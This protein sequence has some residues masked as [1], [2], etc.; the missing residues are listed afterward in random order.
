MS[1]KIIEKLKQDFIDALH[2]LRDVKNREEL[3]AQR[4]L[5]KRKQA[6]FLRQSGTFSDARI[7]YAKGVADKRERQRTMPPLDGKVKPLG[8]DND[9][10]VWICPE[11]GIRHVNYKL[12]KGRVERRKFLGW[13]VLFLKES[14]EPMEYDDA[15]MMLGKGIPFCINCSAKLHKD[16]WMVRRTVGDILKKKLEE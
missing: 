8:V 12:I 14:G 1:E 4:S 6:E 16:V 7:R 5:V 15:K 9:R 3:E 10:V 13:Y 11:C 2:G